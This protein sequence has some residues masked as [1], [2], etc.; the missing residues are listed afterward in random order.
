MRAPTRIVRHL[1]LLL[2]AAALASCARIGPPAPVVHGSSAPPATPVPPPGEQVTIAPAPPLQPARPPVAESTPG[3]V[4]VQ[5]GESLFAIA[6][7]HN[8]PVRAL[9]DAN[10][11]QPPFLLQSGQRL[12]LPRVRSYQVQPGDTLSS[13]GRRFGLG[14]NE[15]V[16]ANGIQPPYGLQTGQVLIL[17]DSALIPASVPASLPILPRAAD[18]PREDRTSSGAIESAGLT[19]PSTQSPQ[20]PP[21]QPTISQTFPPTAATPPRTAP[22]PAPPQQTAVVP[23]LPT[24]RAVDPDPEPPPPRGSRTFQWPVR[25]PVISDFGSKP[26]GLQNDGIN[27][28]A[29]R[30]TPIRAAEAGTVVYAGNELRGFGNLL[31]VRHRDGWVTA[32][33]HAEELLV[34]RGDEV[35]RGQV[36]ARVGNTGGVPVPQL[37]FE[38]RKGSRPVNPREFLGA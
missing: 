19:P 23:G 7:R 33:A 25:G 2:V 17:P 28:S 36:I 26:G 37:H 16:R 38:V 5:S 34:K 15:L 18:S 20:P 24:P 11:L 31:L 14:T 21:G 27:I 9:I 13:L 8:V 10:S 29:P 22:V 35:R 12:M 1:M 3:E 30:G 32:Y 6:R 4:T